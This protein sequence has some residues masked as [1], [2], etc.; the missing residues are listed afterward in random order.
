MASTKLSAFYKNFEEEI[1][2]WT[3]RLRKIRIIFDIWIDVQKKW[4][5]LEGIFMGSAE[6][7]IQLPNDYNR[8]KSINNEFTSLMKKVSAKPKILDVISMEN[9]QKTLERLVESLDT[10]QR[11]L[12]DYLETQ[13]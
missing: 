2:P 7:K 8:F 13:R 9:L 11:A 5:Y 4:V 6:I 1:K 10:I 3:E 12:T